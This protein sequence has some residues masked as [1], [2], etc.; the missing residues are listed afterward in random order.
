M[1]YE[2]VNDGKLRLEPM[3]DAASVNRGSPWR[4]P[5]KEEFQELID[6]CDYEWVTID[7]SSIV[8]GK[9]SGEM[10]TSRINGK[11]VFF[12]TT[13]YLID[14][15]RGTFGLDEYGLYWSASIYYHNKYGYISNN[16]WTSS[17]LDRGAKMSLSFG[18]RYLGQSVR[19]VAKK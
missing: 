9:H 8:V 3:D 15:Q 16:A 5:T 2:G 14:K 4:T 13:G 19:P 6:N 1:G 18:G 11:S 12:P 7:S 17:P 10:F